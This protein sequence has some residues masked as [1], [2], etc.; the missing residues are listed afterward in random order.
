MCDPYSGRADISCGYLL[1][2]KSCSRLHQSNCRNRDENSPDRGR[3]RHI[4]ISYW[5]GNSNGP[6]LCNKQTC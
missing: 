1:S 4:S 6:F 3:W 2:T 5:P